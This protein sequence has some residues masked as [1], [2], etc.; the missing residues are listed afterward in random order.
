ME[1]G[2]V[3]DAD[4]RIRL[5]TALRD[6]GLSFWKGGLRKEARYTRVLSK[7]QALGKTDDGE[8]DDS[9]ESVQKVTEALWQWG[10]EEGARVLDV[11]RV[12]TWRE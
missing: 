11:L 9:D 4:V 8:V 5:L 10:R 1:L 2:P 3:A 12:F 6:A 7:F